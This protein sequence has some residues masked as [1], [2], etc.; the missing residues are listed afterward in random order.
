ME[1][2]PIPQSV[3]DAIELLL[4]PYGATLADISTNNRK[5]MTAKQASM[6]SGLSPKFIRDRAQMKKFVSLRLGNTSKSRVLV[7]KSSFDNWLDSFKH[8][9]TPN[10]EVLNG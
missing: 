7:E 10:P 6:Y 3:V 5:Y 8:K 9:P 1:T 4:A 2:K